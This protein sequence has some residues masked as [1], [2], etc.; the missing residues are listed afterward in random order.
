MAVTS[1]ITQ[2]ISFNETG[3]SG[4]ATSNRTTAVAPQVTMTTSATGV[5]MVWSTTFD[6]T[7]PTLIDI[8][9]YDTNAGSGDAD[10]RGSIR[11]TNIHGIIV[12]LESGECSVGDQAALDPWTSA[13]QGAASA[14]DFV[15]PCSLSFF[16]AASFGPVN[17]TDRTVRVSC[18]AT[19]T[20]VG[21]ITFIG[22]GTII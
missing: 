12:N 10:D 19:K 8:N 1:S 17:S 21:S 18:P 9:L 22:E 7:G 3:G 14:F 2:A 16:N 5:D 20:A 6:L 13:P 4:V 15:G 11:F